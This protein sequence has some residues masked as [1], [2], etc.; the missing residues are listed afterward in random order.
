[1]LLVEDDA[2]IAELVQD[3]LRDHG[4]A[5]THLPDG[6]QMLDTLHS[7]TFAAVVLD[8]GLPGEDGMSLLRKLRPA[9]A[10]P[11][12]MLTARDSEVDE[13]LCLELGAD[14][15][16]A[17]PVRTRSLVARLQKLLASRHDGPALDVDVGSRV[18]KVHGEEVQLT[19][20]EWDVLRVL[21]DHQ[22][23]PVSRDALS[24]AVRGVPYD[25]LDRSL[26]LRVSQLRRKLGDDA[27]QPKWIKSIRGEG[28]LL[29]DK[30]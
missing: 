25:G 9:F 13:V 19:T 5:L 24:L 7:D 27:K 4:F 2:R 26:D 8:I 20:A 21:L 3:V 17:K 18:V 28:Y 23:Q 22:G 10:G 12:L 16:L 30:T 29:V 11:I 1:V 15:F 14:D 6:R